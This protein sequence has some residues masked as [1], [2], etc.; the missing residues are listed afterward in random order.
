MADKFQRGG[1]DSVGFKYV[2]VDGNE[3]W[4]APAVYVTNEGG[5]GGSLAA[6]VE[7]ISAEGVLASLR[8]PVLIAG[9]DKAGT[10][11]NILLENDGTVETSNIDLGAQDNTV[12]TTDTGTFSLISLFKRLLQ[13]FTAQFPAA[14]TAAGNFKVS[15]EESDVHV[16]LAVTL[17]AS[18]SGTGTRTSSDVANTGYNRLLI[19][20]NITANPGDA[21]YSITPVLRAKDPLSGTYATVWT[22]STISSGG[23]IMR[24]YYFGDG[25][26]GGDNTETIP[27]GALGNVF[28]FEGTWGGGFSVT[29]SASAVLMR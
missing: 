29:Y 1:L 6:Q 26:T 2:D 24:T 25:A 13:K 18:Q 8:N 11:R 9:K 16:P 10:I 19:F 3:Q 5:G 7:G 27:M 17:L 4:Y 21:Q 28:Q 20:L 22:G 15:I 12:A 14:L 23:N